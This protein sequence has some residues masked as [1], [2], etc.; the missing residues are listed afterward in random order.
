METSVAQQQPA[1]SNTALGLSSREETGETSENS[2]S[3]V[4]GQSLSENQLGPSEEKTEEKPW[5]ATVS[6]PIG[7]SE[8]EKKKRDFAVQHK[9]L[10]ETRWAV[11]EQLT[12][13]PPRNE[14]TAEV[15][16]G[17]DST[18][19]Q[20]KHVEEKD[21]ASREATATGPTMESSEE[22]KVAHDASREECSG[23]SRPFFCPKPLGY[24]QA[25][26]GYTTK[27]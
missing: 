14:E 13:T 11:L 27:E 19:S 16:E 18:H 5:G 21:T 12:D 7:V 24:I 6:K 2:L 8:E 26:G 15:S 25:T 3:N 1:T 20:E 22:D 10:T 23:T 9:S 4:S 17:H